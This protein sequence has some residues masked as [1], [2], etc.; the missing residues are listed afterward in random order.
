MKRCV[1][2]AGI[3]ELSL[4]KTNHE[5]LR[6][7]CRYTRVVCKQK[8]RRNS[9]FLLQD[10]KMPIKDHPTPVQL[11]TGVGGTHGL[12]SHNLHAGDCEGDPKTSV[13]EEDHGEI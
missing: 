3:Q 4:N 12:S 10:Y 6:F 1:F 7:C 8:K 9:A 2:V 13:F 5:T 11:R